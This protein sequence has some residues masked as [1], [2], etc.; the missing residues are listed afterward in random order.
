MDIFILGQ[1]ADPG[2][3]QAFMTWKVWDIAVWRLTGFTVTIIL[4]LFLKNFLLDR[5]LSRFDL[6]LERTETDAD[7]ML[8]RRVR[9]PLSWVVFTLALYIAFT[10][11]KLPKEMGE[12]VTVVLQ[13][14]GTIFVAWMLYRAIDVLGT[15]LT[16]FTAATDSEMDNQLVPLVRRVL[17]VLLISLC[18]ITVIQQWGYDVTSLVAG[19]GIGGI[20]LALGAQETLS[21][22]FGSIMIF[23]DRPFLPGDWVKSKYGEGIVEE[24]G[25]RSTKIRTFEKTVITVPNSEVASSAIENVS[26][27]PQRRFKKKF[28]LLCSTSADQMEQ[29]LEGFR[30]TLEDHVLVAND[31]ILVSF[32]DM[33]EFTLDVFVHCFIDTVDYATYLGVKQEIFLSFMRIA[34]DAGTDFAF[35]TQTLHVEK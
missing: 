15:V 14:A 6:I 13:T 1:T 29:V 16:R 11:L 24:V 28:G 31:T 4:G 18:V 21:N 20:A 25:M 23:T 7:N 5:M 35:P 26:S 17:R 3:Y 30:K 27:R 32:E 19:L 12:V 8:V 22:W 10:F 33:G 9:Q 2:F 34:A